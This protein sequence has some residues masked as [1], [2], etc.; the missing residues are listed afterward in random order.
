M[1]NDRRRVEMARERYSRL[2][3]G[4]M[5]AQGNALGH[6]DKKIR[7]PERAKQ[8]ERWAVTVERFQRSGNIAR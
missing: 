5:P 2:K 8:M 7:S 1:Q 6:D 3:G 4:N